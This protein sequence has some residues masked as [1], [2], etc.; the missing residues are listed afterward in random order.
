MKAIAMTEPGSPAVLVPQEMP[1][2]DLVTDTDVRVRLV[3]AGINPIDTKLR[4]RGTFYPDLAPH[5]LGC[6][7]AGIVEAVGSA[8]TAFSPGDAVYFCYGGLGGPTGNYAEAIVVPEACLA[9]KPQS[10]SFAEAAAAPLVLITAWEALFDRGRLAAGQRT[11]IH[12]GAG[13]VGHVAIQLAK[14]GGAEVCTTVSTPEKA[15]FVRRLGADYAILYRQES[16]VE[17]ALIWTAGLGVDLA[18][19]TVGGD[20]FA[21][22]FPAIKVYGD[23]VT[24]LEPP[25]DTV[26]AIA[27]QRNLRISLELMLTPLL[28]PLAA[29]IAAQ[30]KILQQCSQWIDAGRLHIHLERTFPL[31]E[32]AAAHALLGT[33]SMRGKLALQ[34]AEEP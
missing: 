28:Q 19:D 27:R 30:A 13:G 12:A 7:G 31:E 33:G 10:L 8:V 25:P 23:L 34:I 9:P 1:T 2:P 15:D 17:A 16:F 24:I 11:L 6:D 20:L 3:A 32:A 21:A 26:W 18:F 4:S 14:L 29:A 5:V 22:T